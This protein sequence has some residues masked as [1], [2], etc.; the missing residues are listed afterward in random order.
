MTNQRFIDMVRQY[1]RNAQRRHTSYAPQVKRLLELRYA[2]IDA[3]EETPEQRI[4]LMQAA[5][6]AVDQEYAPFDRDYSSDAV[7]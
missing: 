4:K 1:A 6:R 7:G 2:S 3:S 5:Q